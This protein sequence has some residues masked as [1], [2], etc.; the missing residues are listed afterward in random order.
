MN[1]FWAN[2]IELMLLGMGSVFDFLSLLVAG[3]I[4][5]S[6]VINKL[7][8]ADPTPTSSSTSPEAEIAA[9]AASAWAKAQA[10]H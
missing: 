2:S 5:M 7:N 10:N 8:V 3:T 1:D 6:S 9:V 4:L